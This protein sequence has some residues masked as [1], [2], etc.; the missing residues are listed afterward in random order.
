MQSIE[1]SNPPNLACHLF[2]LLG[3]GEIV[4]MKLTTVQS[5]LAHRL[6]RYFGVTFET[7]SPRLSIFEL[8][9]S[10]YRHSSYLRQRQIPGRPSVFVDVL[11][12]AIPGEAL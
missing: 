2:I 3:F 8:L 6:T 7:A 5:H 10:D 9:R 1:V 12:S 4:S 11:C